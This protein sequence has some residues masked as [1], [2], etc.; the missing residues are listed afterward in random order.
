[1]PKVKIVASLIIIF[2]TAP[3]WFYVLYQVLQAINASELVWF[4]YWIY[5]PFSLFAS[6]VMK[7]FEE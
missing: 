1:M 4:L 6:V 7:I 5:L 2:I 3:I